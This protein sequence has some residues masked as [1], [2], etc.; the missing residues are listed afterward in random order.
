MGKPVNT[1]G[2]VARILFLAVALILVC[3]CLSF[4]DHYFMVYPTPENQSAFY[5]TYDPDPVL[6]PFISI[7]HVA[8]W[9]A[10]SDGRAG[11]KAAELHREI[12]KVFALQGTDRRTLM[13]LLNEDISSQLDRSGMQV[14]GMTGTEADGF[15][16]RYVDKNGKGTVA[17][18]PVEL[19]D[20]YEVRA[21]SKSHPEKTKLPPLCDGELPVGVTI[22]IDETWSRPG[23]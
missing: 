20:P 10:S 7:H 14:T 8:H 17:L 22:V 13:T 23:A 12:T 1:S 2:W 19:V 3:A 15:Q 9:G 11:R 6:K 21:W 18:K 16:F 5:K 4:A